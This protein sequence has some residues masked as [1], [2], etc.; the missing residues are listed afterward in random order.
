MYNFITDWEKIL[1]RKKALAQF[2]S[3]GSR[4]PGPAGENLASFTRV[5][6]R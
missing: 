3:S 4:G 1:R 2:Y 6:R 5:P